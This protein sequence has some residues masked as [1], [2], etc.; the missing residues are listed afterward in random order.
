MRFVGCLSHVL[1]VSICLGA[2]QAHAQSTLSIHRACIDGGT[3]ETLLLRYW[4]PAPDNGI[5]EPVCVVKAAALDTLP[6]RSVQLV[7][8]RRSGAGAVVMLEFD[9]S[10]TTAI[11][12][13]SRD[14]VGRLMAVV[15][16]DRIVATPVISR[17]LSSNTLPLGAATEAEVRRI[18][19][20]V[21]PTAEGTK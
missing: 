9:E 1:A 20:A 8:D 4:P 21:N 6:I 16:R 2:G 12:K 10:A 13:M 19:E 11:E 5:P 15:V 18:L 14:N 3:G 17:V 7:P